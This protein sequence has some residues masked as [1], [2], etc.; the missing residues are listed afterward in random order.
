MQPVMNRGWQHTLCYWSE[1]L[2]KSECNPWW[3]GDGNS[4]LLS[5]TQGIERVRMQPVMNRGWQLC[6]SYILYSYVLVR[7]QPVMNRGWQLSYYTA[8]RLS[9]FVRMQ[10][11][12]NRGWQHDSPP[13]MHLLDYVR[14]QPVMNRGWQLPIF[15]I[16]I[17]RGCMSE[18]NPWWIGDGNFCRFRLRS[19]LLY[20]PN[21]TR[22]E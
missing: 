3:I 22:D 5:L 10:P 2:H 7:M 8:G 13:S 21:A 18:C 15:V 19:P 16:K 12:M 20:G 6:C 4:G 17:Q 11:V 14:M 1:L 9:R